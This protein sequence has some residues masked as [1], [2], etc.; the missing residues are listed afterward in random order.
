M[1]GTAVSLIGE[2]D[3]TFG[4]KKFPTLSSTIKAQ[5]CVNN[6]IS[7]ATVMYR[8]SCAE[9]YGS[10]DEKFCAAEDYEMW[11]RWRNKGV[12]FANLEEKLVLYRIP[13]NLRRN[14]LNWRCN[15]QAKL[16]HFD[17]KYFFKNLLGVFLVF[18]AW[19]FPPRFFEPIYLKWVATKT[20]H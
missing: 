20:K 8:K 16:L 9:M 5:L 14:R 3:S 12:E 15:L 13:N 4:Q 19:L 11:L 10:Y 1:V 7:H 17:K 6:P 2:N 18:I